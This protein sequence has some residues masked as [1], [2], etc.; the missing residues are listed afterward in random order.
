MLGIEDS[1]IFEGFIPDDE[2]GDYYHSADV[3]VSPSINEPFGLTVTEAVEAGTP[4]VATSS[5]AEE[6]LPGNA[7]VSVEP[8]SDSI[9]KGIEAALDQEIGE[10]DSRSWKEVAE[11]TMEVYQELS[12]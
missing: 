3:F 10:F 1:V 6:V 7:V 4:V 11:E 2:L 8:D 12:R 9:M 5:G